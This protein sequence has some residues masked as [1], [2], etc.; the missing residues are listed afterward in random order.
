M[1]RP[2]RPLFHTHCHKINTPYLP[3]AGR[4]GNQKILQAEGR[5]LSE[6][7]QGITRSDGEYS[8]P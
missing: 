2:S 4:S 8:S 7:K 3:K 6:A 1:Y 5:T